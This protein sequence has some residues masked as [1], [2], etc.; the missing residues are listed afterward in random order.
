MKWRH[1]CCFHSSQNGDFL[2]YLPLFLLRQQLVGKVRQ[3][4]G[5]CKWASNDLI[6]LNIVDI[7]RISKM[8]NY[9]IWKIQLRDPCSLMY[10]VECLLLASMLNVPI[11]SLCSMFLKRGASMDDL[12]G[13]M[14][15]HEC[16]FVALKLFFSPSSELLHEWYNCNYRKKHSINTRE[17]SLTSISTYTLNSGQPVHSVLKWWWSLVR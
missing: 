16:T 6:E 9:P 11:T 12:L 10:N 7:S 2:L 14:S 17:N 4:Y 5:A 3:W 15:T 1:L 13:Q 8:M